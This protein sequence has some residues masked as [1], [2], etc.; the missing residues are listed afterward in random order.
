MC[1]S[2]TILQ[3]RTKR[4][5]FQVVCMNIGFINFYK[6]HCYA[7][8]GGFK[9]GDMEDDVKIYQGGGV[10]RNTISVVAHHKHQSWWEV[11]KGKGGGG[12][13]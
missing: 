9:L 1:R 11:C 3:Y 2:C 6:T 13:G 12:V 5:L 4:E 10:K 7:G 8:E